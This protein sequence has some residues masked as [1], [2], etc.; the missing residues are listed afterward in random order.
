VVGKAEQ[1]PGK[2]NPWFV[3]TS[4]K[5]GDLDT[6]ELYVDL[7]CARGDMENR[8]KEQQLA[9]F[10]DRTSRQSL[11][12]NQRRLW[13]CTFAYLLVAGLRR[14]GLTGSQLE[15]AQAGTLRTRLLKLEAVINASVRRVVV[16]LSSVFPLQTVFL[17]ALRTLRTY[18]ARR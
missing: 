15:H 16:S 14:L 4:L 2:G 11:Q 18:S 3:V 6:R 7:Y 8:S 13:P 9:L 12:A 10:A 17:N 1:P 5:P